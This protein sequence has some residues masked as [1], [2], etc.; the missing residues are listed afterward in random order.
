MKERIRSFDLIRVISAWIIVICHFAEMVIG[1]PNF[2]YF[3]EFLFHHAN[4]KWGETTIVTVFFILSGASLYYNHKEVTA[5]ELPKFYWGR[6]KGLFPMFYIAWIVLYLENVMKYGSFAYLGSRKLLLLTI[7]GMDGYLYDLFPG[8][9]YIIGEWFLGALVILYLLY[10]LMTWCMKHCRWITTIVLSLLFLSLFFKSFIPL[11]NERNPFTCL[12]SFWAGMMF[13]EY[14]KQIM[15]QKWLTVVALVIGLIITFVTLPIP[16]LLCMQVLA[17]CIFLVLSR[18]GEPLMT[19]KPLASFI[20]FGSKISYGIFLLQH[21]MMSRVAHRFDGYGVGGIKL[22][23]VLLLVFV[24]IYILA[25]LLLI[26]NKLVL[27]LPPVKWIDRWTDKI[28]KA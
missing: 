11:S 9:Y 17:V 2:G 28:A 22:F 3:P 10:P 26:V 12:L 6:I 15:D 16:S 1:D 24:V 20:G 18:V 23:G 7:T 4:G 19:I 8:N 14:R 27:K 25:Y 21:V 13:I 5:K